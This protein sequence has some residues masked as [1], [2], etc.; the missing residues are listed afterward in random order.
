MALKRL[1]ATR[2]ETVAQKVSTPEGQRLR[3]IAAL[4][5]EREQ[6]VARNLSERVADVDAELERLGE[7]RPFE[8]RRP[9]ADRS[10][11][12]ASVAEAR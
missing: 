6:L 12:P 1:T 5:V 4:H 8:E 3:Y 7:P 2:A 10:P 11:L 9:G